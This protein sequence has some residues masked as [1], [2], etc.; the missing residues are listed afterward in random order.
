M[1]ALGAVLLVALTVG[2]MT[3]VIQRAAIRYRLAERAVETTLLG[4]VIARVPYSDIPSPDHVRVATEAELLRTGEIWRAGKIGIRGI[5]TR[6][7]GRKVIITRRTGD[8]TVITPDEPDAFVQEIQERII[9]AALPPR[10]A[11][12]PYW[13]GMRSTPSAPAEPE[14]KDEGRRY[15]G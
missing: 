4:A 1:L 13:G 9:A 11:G 8:I 5:E 14:R 2:M 12:E 10:S 15:F 6:A 3:G 7:F